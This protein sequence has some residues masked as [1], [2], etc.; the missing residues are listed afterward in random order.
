MDLEDSKIVDLYWRRSEEDGLPIALESFD[1]LPISKLDMARNIGTEEN[2]DWIW[3]MNGRKTIASAA[4]YVQQTGETYTV[5]DS[6]SLEALTLMLREDDTLSWDV[7]D[8]RFNPLYLT[9]TDGSR[10]TLFTAA[11]GTNAFW[12][13]GKWQEYQFGSTI[14]DLFGVPLESK[15]YTEQDGILTAHMESADPILLKWVEVDFAKGGDL[16]ERRIMSEVL[17][18]MRYEYDEEHHC[19]RETW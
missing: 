16:V 1:M 14:F 10:A 15:G 9:Y 6:A 18:Q 17:R 5:S 13:Y 7:E 12:Q 4:L 8:C 3:L 19:V 11:S 2:P